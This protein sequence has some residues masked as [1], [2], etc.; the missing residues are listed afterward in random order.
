MWSHLPRKA[1]KEAF[2]NGFQKGGEYFIESKRLNTKDWLAR[3]REYVRL[4]EMGILQE[5][6]SMSLEIYPTRHKKQ[7]G[8]KYI[9]CKDCGAEKQ[10]E[11]TKNR[12]CFDCINLSRERK[13][14]V[15]HTV[16]CKDCNKTFDI[17]KGEH[18]YFVKKGLSMPKRCVNCRG[19]SYVSSNTSQTLN[20]SSNTGF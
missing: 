5:Q 15:I 20:N 13:Q 7:K 10:E 9:I 8:V 2:Y 16:I 1:I 6:D 18:D 4:F 14:K 12:Q 3:F 17:T 11:Y 19:N